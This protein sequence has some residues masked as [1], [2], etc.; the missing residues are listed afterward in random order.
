MKRYF[1]SGLLMMLPN[2]R[3]LIIS[4]QHQLM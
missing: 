1:I 4:I 3:R 2:L